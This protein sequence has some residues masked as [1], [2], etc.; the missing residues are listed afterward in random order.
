[1]TYGG[2]VFDPLHPAFSFIAYGL[3]G[4]FIFAFYHV[5]GLSETIT[6]SVI[7]SA[8]QF[9]ISSTWITPLAAGVWAFG[10]NLPVVALAFI[11]E[12]KLANLRQAKFVVVAVVYGAMFVLLTLLVGALT[13]VEKMPAVVFRGNFLDGLL[14]GLGL[15]IGIEGGEAFVH[16]VE[17]HRAEKREK[18]LERH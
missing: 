13:G 16:S 3:A 12:R 5:R 6:T 7:V 11:F 17:H 10:V 18:K 9:A 8:L 14:I 1:M 2:A 15:G 4:G